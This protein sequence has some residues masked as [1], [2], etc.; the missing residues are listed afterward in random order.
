MSAETTDAMNAYV[1]RIRHLK[2]RA[3]AE[4]YVAWKLGN[5]AEPEFAASGL[6]YMGAQAVRLAVAEM[7]TV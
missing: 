2:K 1:G 7:L 3:Y 5:G 4:Q 6:S